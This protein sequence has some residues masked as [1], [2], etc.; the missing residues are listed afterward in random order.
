MCG[1]V[2]ICVRFSS[3]AAMLHYRSI[4]GALVVSLLL[5]SSTTAA[6]RR[7]TPQFQIYLPHIDTSERCA[8]PWVG[9]LVLPAVPL[10]F[11]DDGDIWLFHATNCSVERLMQG[12]NT[13]AF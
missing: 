11:I 3:G 7:L 2:L 12:S 9:P 4:L 5:L 10:A 13:S 1:E 6:P 8:A